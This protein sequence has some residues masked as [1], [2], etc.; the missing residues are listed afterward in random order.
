MGAV[1]SAYAA[2]MP[3]FDPVNQHIWYTDMD[4]GFYVVK[5]TNGTWITDI[6]EKTV[7]HGV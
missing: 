2:A 3:Q 7:S 6:I 5:P 4:H 1:Y